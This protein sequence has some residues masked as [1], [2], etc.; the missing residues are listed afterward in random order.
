MHR[1]LRILSIALIT[2][3]IVVLVDVALTLVWKEPVSTVYGSIR[4]NEAARELDELN[5][6]FRAKAEVAEVSTADREEQSK[7]LARLF[8][9]ELETGTGMG[10]IEIPAIDVNSVVVQ[11]TDTSSLQKGPGHYPETGLPGEGTT[12]GIAGHRTT[13]LAPFH[14]L[15]KLEP[16]DRITLEMP[17]GTFEYTVEGT[18]IV[19]PED[20]E[21]VD[22]V[23]Y[24]R[25]VLTACHP[26]YSAA[27]RVVAFAKLESMDLLGADQTG[28]WVNP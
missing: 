26:L 3:G 19:E 5:E 9:A 1:A 25:L 6:R 10:R 28:A 12:I 16:R 22:D 15:D 7:E 23:G 4:Q 2:A 20:V 13:Y 11:G 8:E 27:Q 21:V 17:Y 24:E 18:G 14:D